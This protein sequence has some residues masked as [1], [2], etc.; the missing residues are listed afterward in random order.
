M[1]AISETSF[2]GVRIVSF[3]G[4]DKMVEQADIYGSRAVFQAASYRVVLRRGLGIAGRV[5]VEH[6]QSVGFIKNGYLQG[7]VQIE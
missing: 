4:D 6:Y 5:I 7:G 3:I 1:P 2:V